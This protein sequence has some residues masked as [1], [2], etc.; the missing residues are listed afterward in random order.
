[1]LGQEVGGIDRFIVLLVL[2]VD[3]KQG[4]VVDTLA[5]ETLPMV[6]AGL[7]VIGMIPHVPLAKKGGGESGIL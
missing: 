4:T 1:M 2:A 3:V 7:R 5:F 6:E